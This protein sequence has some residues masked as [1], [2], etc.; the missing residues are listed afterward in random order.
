MTSQRNSRKTS[1]IF[2]NCTS[3]LYLLNRLN[4]TSLTLAF[5]L[6]V[7]PGL[8]EYIFSQLDTTWKVKTSLV[9][10]I[11]ENTKGSLLETESFTQA[12][13]TKN[14]FQYQFDAIPKSPSIRVKIAKNKRLNHTICFI[15]RLLG[16]LDQDQQFYTHINRVLV[17]TKKSY[18]K[19][20]HMAK[21]SSCNDIIRPQTITLTR[22]VAFVSPFS[23]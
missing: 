5:Y 20:D 6:N 13:S 17:I 12:K 23:S 1:V 4:T 14:R 15:W 10:E 7:I 11:Y 16:L 9:Q 19:Y 21:P 2:D 22:A 8:I 18:K 3:S